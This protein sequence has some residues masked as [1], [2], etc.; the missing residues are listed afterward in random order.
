MA[1]TPSP[2]ARAR[3]RSRAVR[4]WA[5]GAVLGVLAVLGVVSAV[6]LASSQRQRAQA[7][8]AHRMVSLSEKE[9]SRGVRE[10][11]DGSNNA[12]SISR[13]R[14]ATAGAMR[15]A[16]W[17]AYFASYIAKKAGV[18]LGW[19]GEGMGYVPYIRDWAHKTSR[20]RHTPKPGYLI[21]F[22]QHV[23]VVEHVYSNHTL[24]SIE[25]N[26]GN[27]V[28]REYQR[29]SDATGYV[30][31][32]DG[33]SI[34]SPS[35]PHPQATTVN[36]QKLVARM[37][38]YPDTTPAVGQTVEFSSQDSSGNVVK[39]S[40][41][42][43]GD[44]KWDSHGSSAS[45][46]YT[47]AG[48][49]TVKLQ[50]SD[51]SHHHSTATTKIVVHDDQPPTARLSLGSTR[52][53][54]GD[55][56]SFDA[57]GSTDR[58]GDVAGYAWDFI[59]NGEFQPGPAQLRHSWSQPG[60]YTVRGR[61]IYPG[62]RV[63][64]PPRGGP[65]LGWAPPVADA[66]CS[67]TVVPAGG[68]VHC[69]SDDSRSP[70]DVQKHE[71]DMQGDG[72]YDL[73]GSAVDFT[74]SRPGTYTVRL[75]VTDEHGRTDDDTTRVTVDDAAPQA[76]LAAP[77]TRTLNTPLTFDATGS[78]D[79]D[80]AIVK[81]EWDTGSG[82]HTGGSRFSPTFTQ[83]GT[84]TVR[85]RV[86]DDF[87]KTTTTSYTF[88]LSN[89]APAALIGLPL[90][91][92]TGTPATFDGTGS[93]D[94]DGTVVKYQWDL[95]GNGT[96]ES[97]GAQP[98]WTYTT[99]GTYTVKL[100]VTDALGAVSAVVTAQVTVAAA[101]DAPPV[102]VLSFPGSGL[103][104]GQPIRLSAAGSSDPDGTIAKYQWDVDGDG[105]VDATTAVNYLDW[106]Y[107]LPGA[108]VVTLTVTDNSYAQASKSA[109]LTIR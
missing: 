15:G 49:Y 54:P 50:V 45:Y 70:Y 11:P 1:W 23:G 98:S 40:W 85:L 56:I 61:A 109:V 69:V 12:P 37:R 63:G 47:A 82:W 38:A 4:P 67:P 108:Y 64:E 8:V 97:S 13:Y 62:G 16:P 6:A 10:V 91:P 89:Q 93:S 95:N 20:W 80:G 7:A 79:S 24:T 102:P 18:P 33:G 65:V 55:E 32:A 88:T 21:T 14:T 66:S 59:G 3:A 48:T 86:T 90:H 71:W 74:Y 34:E 73:R 29:W 43:N 41:D 22:P 26:A 84:Y 92:V 76:K 9:L 96:Y 35:A 81:Y 60:T 52:V 53:H 77:A 51:K 94:P 105:A 83:A 44:G 87:G 19:H 103:V 2:P 36:G 104:A 58:E 28:R 101:G 5:I 27:A 57:S 75:R 107:T 17:C 99:A 68:S 46:R 39:R 30:R 100:K 25:G 42:L 106:T 78:S 72:S 31:L